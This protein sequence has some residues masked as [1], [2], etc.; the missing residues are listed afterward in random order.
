MGTLSISLASVH[1]AKGSDPFAAEIVLK[2][3]LHGGKFKV[4][5]RIYSMPEPGRIQVQFMTENG[6]I[7]HLI[8]DMGLFEFFSMCANLPDQE[9][10]RC[11]SYAANNFR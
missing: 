1:G 6:E 11:A 7:R 2:C 4:E 5:N 10:F 3:L 8:V 9:I